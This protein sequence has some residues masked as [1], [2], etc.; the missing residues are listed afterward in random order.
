MPIRASRP[1]PISRM[2]SQLVCAVST[3]CDAAG[4]LVCATGVA[5]VTASCGDVRPESVLT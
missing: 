1:T 3:D 4:S 5:L 2:G